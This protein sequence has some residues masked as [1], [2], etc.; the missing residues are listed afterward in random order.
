[1]NNSSQYVILV[2]YASLLLILIIFAVGMHLLLGKQKAKNYK[3]QIQEA[4]QRFEKELMQIKLELQEKAFH[5]MSSEIHDNIGQVLSSVALT[6]QSIS[7]TKTNAQE[8]QSII[9]HSVLRINEVTGELRNL[10]HMLNGPLV[11]RIGLINAIKKEIGY[12]RLNDKLKI[13]FV[14]P[15]G[16]EAPTLSGSQT[17]L[18]FRIVQEAVQNVIRHANATIMEI[19]ISYNDTGKNLQLQIS[20]NGNGFLKNE[21]DYTG[22]GILTMRDRAK[23]LN[24]KLQIG[25]NQTGGSTISLSLNI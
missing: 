20:D 17:L 12:L 19:A 1:M 3:M 18:L 8:M 9:N 10:S 7:P 4:D 16:S 11:E 15:T 22:L 24:G 2:V 13:S 23:L 6:L 21:D 25:D 14:Y 5:N